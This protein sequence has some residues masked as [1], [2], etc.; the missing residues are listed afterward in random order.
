MC[1]HYEF[2]IC[3]VTFHNSLQCVFVAFEYLNVKDLCEDIL[4]VW[5]G[6]K[7][8]RQKNHTSITSVTL[9]PLQINKY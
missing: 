3:I 5:Q 9:D 6:E 1:L 4:V 2:D 8:N 7:I